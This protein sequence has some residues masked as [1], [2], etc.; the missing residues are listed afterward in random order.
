MDVHLPPEDI[1]PPLVPI[2]F[3]LGQPFDAPFNLLSNKWESPR[4]AFDTSSSS[5]RSSVLSTPPSSPLCDTPTSEFDAGSLYLDPEQDYLAYTQQEY[6]MP[7]KRASLS[8]ILIP[9][10]LLYPLPSLSDTSE[11]PRSSTRARSSSSSRGSEHIPTLSPQYEAASLASSRNSPPPDFLL[12]DDPFANYTGARP[13]Q[14]HYGSTTSPPHSRQTSLSRR[15]SAKQPRSP[16]ATEPSSPVMLPCSSPPPVQCR[17][18]SSP[19]GPVSG[20]QLRPAYTRPAFA[21]RPSH[22]SLHT[23]SQTDFNY[24][25]KVC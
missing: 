1:G 17:S 18:A 20:R 3:H 21:P 19:T 25:I 23:L 2:H 10:F 13:L 14:P 9:P 11:S 7:K 22:P 8:S 24:P 16:L 4:C 12:D 5:A 6:R 15:T